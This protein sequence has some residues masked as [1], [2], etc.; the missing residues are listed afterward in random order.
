MRFHRSIA[1]LINKD[2]LVGPCRA[3]TDDISRKKEQIQNGRLGNYNVLIPLKKYV[4]GF[5][6]SRVP[7]PVH[8]QF[9]IERGGGADRIWTQVRGGMSAAP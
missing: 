7:V 5:D 4:F 8:G 6:L 2:H 3:M 9:V 1:T